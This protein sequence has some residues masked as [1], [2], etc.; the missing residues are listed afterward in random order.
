MTVSIQPKIDTTETRL[1][2]IPKNLCSCQALI[3]CRFQ[4][5]LKEKLETWSVSRF[6]D[7]TSPS[8]FGEVTW[9]ISHFMGRSVFHR[10]AFFVILQIGLWNSQSVKHRSKIFRVHGNSENP[11]KFLEVT[12]PKSCIFKNRVFQEFGL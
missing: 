8:D 9:P 2:K 12:M 11:V 7:M 6:D 4:F 5:S 1:L 10:R 3:K